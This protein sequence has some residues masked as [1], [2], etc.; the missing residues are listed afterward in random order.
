M[1]KLQAMETFLNALTKNIA[2]PTSAVYLPLGYS[3]PDRSWQILQ[4]HGDAEMK[5]LSDLFPTLNEPDLV[6]ALGLLLRVAISDMK[7]Q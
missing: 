6:S 1:F 7:V 5:T 2:N 3:L 4:E